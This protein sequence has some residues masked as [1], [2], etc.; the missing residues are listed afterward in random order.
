MTTITIPRD[1]YVQ[2]ADDEGRD[3]YAARTIT[4]AAVLWQEAEPS[5]R[6]WGF[7]DGDQGSDSNSTIV[8]V[9]SYDS[10]NPR[11]W[12]ASPDE[13]MEGLYPADDL[14]FAIVAS[15]FNIGD[16]IDPNERVE[17]GHV[18]TRTVEKIDSDGMVH[19]REHN[20]GELRYVGP[21]ALSLW[22]VVLA[23]PAVATGT[24]APRTFV[25]TVPA[26]YA[27]TLQVIHN[28][29]GDDSDVTVRE[30]R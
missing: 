3:F 26:D 14:P 15:P 11:M 29:A 10:I 22:H 19:A 2:R 17:G 23:E 18:Y 7:E 1:D 24:P 28:W 6:N 8:F 27:T 25:V 12:F 20:S 13:D 9:E 30:A 21:N 5:R 4:A 16:V